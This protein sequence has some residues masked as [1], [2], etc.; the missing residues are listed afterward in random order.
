MPLTKPNK[1]GTMHFISR[2]KICTIRINGKKLEPL[3]KQV[4]KK[5]RKASPVTD[6]INEHASLHTHYD[7]GDA[8]NDAGNDEDD[9]EF[10]GDAGD[11]GGSRANLEE[12]LVQR[13]ALHSQYFQQYSSN[14]SHLLEG[15]K[16][17]KQEMQD[18]VNDKSRRCPCPTCGLTGRS[19]ESLPVA[20][21]TWDRL[22]EIQ[23]PAMYCDACKTRYNVYPSQL[24]CLPTTLRDASSPLV[25]HG[26]RRPLWWATSILQQF[27]LLEFH[28][29][30]VGAERF[31]AALLDNWGR[32]GGV[33]LA[34]PLTS[35]RIGLYLALQEY[36]I[37][38]NK[39]L[40]L[41][42]GVVEGWPAGLL[43]GCPCCNGASTTPG[44]MP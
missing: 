5:K 14:Q 11:H 21:V 25:R 19:Y 12:L 22:L 9:P 35:L 37:L 38:Q 13:K 29:R 6:V 7:L 20:I 40:D 24:S 18:L 27:D 41:P 43:N 39:L 31:C 3:G 17:A 28:L 4:S 36:Q 32:N 26:V 42:E 33:D 10:A 34:P 44:K 23:V 8:E 15:E 16:R 1:N 2:K 30:R